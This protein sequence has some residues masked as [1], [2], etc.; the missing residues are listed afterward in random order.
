M[1]AQPEESLQREIGLAVRRTGTRRPRGVLH[2]TNPGTL[3]T[4]RRGKVV[5]WLL[6]TRIPGHGPSCCARTRG[7]RRQQRCLPEN[8]VGADIGI[9]DRGLVVGQ[10]PYSAGIRVACHAIT[11]HSP[12][13]FRNVPVL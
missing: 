2:S 10:S 4:L 7:R 12:S 13:R 3:Q 8:P 5:K 9:N 11:R 6:R 1:V